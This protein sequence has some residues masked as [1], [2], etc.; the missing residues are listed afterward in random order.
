MLPTL[1]ITLREG[2]EAALIVGIVAAFLVR[3]GRRDA[4]RWMWLGVGLAV[5]LC[6]AVAIGLEVVG[7]SLP[8]RRQ[9]GLET[10]VGVIAVG[11]I[12][13]MI[14]WMRRHSRQLK[15]S[16]QASA[17]G[18]LASGSTIALVGMAFLAVLREGLETAVFLLAVFQDATDPG[19]AGFGAVL[20]LVLAAA[21]GWG[22]YRGG[23]R[24]N[25][26]RFFRVTGVVLAFVAAG[27]L[28]TAVHT[29]HEAGWI[30]VLQARAVDLTWLVHQ[31]TVSGSLLTG[32]LGLQ[33]VPTVAEAAAYLLFA[34]PLAL[35]VAW[36]QGGPRRPGRRA[37]RGVVTAALAALAALVVGG[38]GGGDG[39]GAKAAGAKTVKVTL[40]DD[41][42]S[43]QDL[44][45]PAGPTTFEVT[46]GGS[47][48]TTEFEVFDG[49]RILGE[50]E[51][52]T[53]GLKRSFSLTLKSGDFVLSCSGGSQEPT[54]KLT[55][56]DGGAG[57]G[58][59]DAGA[60][61]A[62]GTYRDYL[63][64]QSDALVT[65]TTAFAAAVRDGD[66]AKARALYAPARV[67]Y[68]RIEP[69][70]ESFGDLDPA[71]DARAGDVPK[72]E[73][74]GF[75]VLERAL[76]VTGTTKRHGAVADKLVADV[77]RLQALVRTVELEPA[78][79]A[80]G[81]VELLGEVSKSKVTGEEER[82]SRI[83]LLDFKAN[84]E[85]AR[86]AYDAVA[87]LLP[88]DADGE[89]LESRFASVDSTLD[90]YRKG[91]GF[92]SYDDLTRA[93]TRALSQAIDALAEPLSQVPARIVA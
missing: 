8:Q 81:A 33:P 14:V 68:E 52:V 35:F 11:M 46:G 65:A 45:L 76:W 29:A 28:A 18:A 62:V 6:L 59:A 10:V 20:G 5:G 49:S 4:L 26:S 30:E 84:V 17:A 9:E 25:L 75:H 73:W 38:C 89:R 22:L 69:V 48:R 34:V 83:D 21:I 61:E 15:G 74:T 90:R 87:P 63:E 32:M 37:R 47:G 56:T 67:P 60:D 13:Y 16:L 58:R 23:V 85:G 82:Y 1:V 2:V 86:A 50:V 72:A 54:G 71:I 53:P 27:L 66:V 64:R 51:N 41:G 42:C 78:Q 79:V 92:V 43:P 7:E 57:A 39:G 70:A 19:A 91:D 3:E 40:T 80:N 55:V 93:D 31:G 24:I 44:S 77:K 36:P 12:T 88:A